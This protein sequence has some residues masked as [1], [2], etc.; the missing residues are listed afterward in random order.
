MCVCVCVCG[1]CP[2]SHAHVFVSSINTVSLE[3][4]NQHVNVKIS[5]YDV[6]QISDEFENVCTPL[7]ILQKR[8]YQNLTWVM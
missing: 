8:N 2:S 7:N 1:K 5:K 4:F 6:V 3:R